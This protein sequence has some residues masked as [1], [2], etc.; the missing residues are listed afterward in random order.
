MCFRVGLLSTKVISQC[1]K[2]N[3]VGT[4]S[5]TNR[6]FDSTNKILFGKADGFFALVITL[7]NTLMLELAVNKLAEDIKAVSY[8]LDDFCNFGDEIL[9]LPFPFVGKSRGLV[10]PRCPPTKRRKE[11]PLPTALPPKLAK[12]RVQKPSTSDISDERSLRSYT[13]RRC[14]SESIEAPQSTTST[15]P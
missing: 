6:G 5:R 8:E 9:E 2:G 14:P 13:M 4:C 7:S 15:A 12:R 3:V 11:K 10:S 1:C